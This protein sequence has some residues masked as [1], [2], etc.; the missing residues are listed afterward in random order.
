MITIYSYNIAEGTLENPTI[1]EL[2]AIFESD[3]V[4]IWVDLES[5][6]AKESEILHN[7]FDFHELAIEDCTAMDIEEAKLDD[8]EDYF[9]LVFHSV[10]FNRE[11]LNFDIVEMDMFFGKNFVVTYHKK[12]T[13][14]IKML[15]KKLEKEIDFMGRGTDE[16]LHAIVDLM[17]DNYILSFKKLDRSILQIESEIF[18]QPSKKTFNNLFK[19]KR[20]LINLKR[21]IAP[22]EEV[23]SILGNSEH[24]LIQE[25]NKF[26]FQ[27]VHDHISNIE[28][29]LQSYIEMVT[30]TMDTYVSITTHRMNTVMQ[31]LTVVATM[32]LIPT[33]IASI[34]GMNVKLPFQN[35]QYGFSIVITI[36]FISIIAMLWYFKKKDWF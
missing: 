2:P 9:F 14:G 8:Y 22:E 20:G 30:G 24:I 11:N 32:V 10:F 34:Y 35:N 4:D 19:L 1:N 13:P 5:P 29:R 3:N 25:E 27:D 18:S 15:K 6:T 36:S 23:I 26:Y 12:P 7:V 31:T 16:I 33:L 28:G 21:I 17:V